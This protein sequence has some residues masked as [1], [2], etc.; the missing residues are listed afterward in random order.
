MT[1]ESVMFALLRK[2]ICGNQADAESVLADRERLY[3]LLPSLYRLSKSHDVAH[4]VG[5]GLSSLGLLGQ[6]EWSAKFKKQQ[7]LAVYRY[8]TINYEL[9]EIC[10]CLEREKI[11][12][13]PLKGSVI[14]A[15]Y[16]QPWMRTSCDIDILVREENLNRATEALTNALGYTFKDRGSHDISLFSPSGVHLEL[17]FDLIE[18]IR[19][20]MAVSI[21]SEVWHYAEPI[22]GKKYHCALPDELFYF[23]HILHMAKHFENGGCGV[24]PF[25]DLWILNHRLDFERSKR[26]AL[27]EKGAL[28]T[29]SEAVCKLS[30][31]WFSDGKGDEM[32]DQLSRF[33]LDGGVYGTIE[34]SVKVNQKKKGGRI[35]YVFSRLFVP[36]SI[37]KERYPILRKHRILLPICQVRRWIDMLKGGRLG[38]SVEELKISGKISQ[39]KEQSTAELLS[40]IGL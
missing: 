32:T 19:D 36:Y 22:E 37:L 39:T 13:L 21:L 4:L 27:L 23:Y 9:A 26:S 7:M 6:D 29:F 10:K 14:R 38:R 3:E 31:V 24:R 20:P 12:F 8:E 2:E 40:K 17:H 25:L 28:L 34:N 15:Y 30:E 1:A 11:A 5:D 33:V 35:R 18:A 16:P